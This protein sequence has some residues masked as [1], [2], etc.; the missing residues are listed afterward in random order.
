MEVT[1][2]TAHTAAGTPVLWKG[3]GG[4][5]KVANFEQSI[6]IFARTVTAGGPSARLHKGYLVDA[7]FGSD[8]Q[9]RDREI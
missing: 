4:T 6:S 9:R 7:A 1:H 3:Q 8:R 5:Q 2:S